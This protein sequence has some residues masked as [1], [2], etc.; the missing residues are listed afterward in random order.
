M[1]LELE[2]ADRVRDALERVGDAVRVVVERVDAP[3]VAGAVVR[4]VADPVDRRVAHVDVRAR[5]V[6]LEPQHVRAVGKLARLHPPEQVEVLRDAAVAVGARRCPA[7]V[8]VPRV[9]AHLRGR[10]AV[11]VGEAV[12]DEP[13]GETRRA[14][15]SSRTRDS[16][17]RPS[18]SPASAPPRRSTS[19][20]S[21]SS[22]SGL[23]SSKRRWQ[24]AAVL[25]GEAEVQD[26]RLGV[27][28]VQVAVR[29]GRK[30]RDDAPAVFAGAI[31]LGDDGAQEI[32]RRRRP[33]P[34]GRRRRGAVGPLRGLR[35]AGV[36]RRCSTH[37]VLFMNKRNAFV[38]LTGG[39]RTRHWRVSQC[40][41]GRSPGNPRQ[42]KAFRRG[43][44][45]ARDG[46]VHKS[47]G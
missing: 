12:L 37:R 6:D 1:V 32:R 19:S 3:L 46:V 42:H 41:I 43:A 22:F 17:A 25:G 24:R 11:D 20:N 45:A 16:D 26:D 10:L 38:I 23:V 39:V 9:R 36:L 2:R 8:S 15:R 40:G 47:C 4:R 5:H 34:R 13:L 7:S 14:R 21:T 29:L 44:S 18:R 28:V 30:A 33:S 27:A 31:V 35:S